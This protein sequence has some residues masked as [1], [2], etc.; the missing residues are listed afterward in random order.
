MG[1][2]TGI[3]IIILSTRLLDIESA[4][5]LQSIYLIINSLTTNSSAVANRILARKKNK[6]HAYTISALILLLSAVTYTTEHFLC[7]TTTIYV[8]SGYVIK[9]ANKLSDC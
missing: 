1:L 2:I 4:I 9:Q 7:V 5:L 8:C 6:P 3:L